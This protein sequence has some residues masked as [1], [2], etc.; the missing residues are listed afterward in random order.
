MDKDLELLTA[1]SH[2]FDGGNYDCAYVGR[3]DPVGS[4]MKHGDPDHTSFAHRAG[5]IRG[6]YSSFELHE[7]ADPSLRAKVAYIRMVHERI[8]RLGQRA[9]ALELAVKLILEL[10]AAEDGDSVVCLGET[11]RRDLKNLLQEGGGA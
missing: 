1:E 8:Y 5:Y 6:F 9:D 7:I 2:G 4:F 11:T 3:F 10:D